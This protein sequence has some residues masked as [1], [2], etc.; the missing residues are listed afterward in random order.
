LWHNPA[1]E[2]IYFDFPGALALTTGL[3]IWLAM[4]QIRHVQQH[5]D[6]VPAAF[7]DRISLEQHRKAADYT[8]AKS[9][10]RCCK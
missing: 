8:V 2:Y 6:S 10:F 7:T 1:D 4:R 9:R 3:R 5:R